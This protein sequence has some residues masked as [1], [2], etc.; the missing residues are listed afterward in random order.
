[1]LMAK[2]NYHLI[3]LKINI[4]SDAVVAHTNRLEKMHR[5]ALPVAI[6]GT[7]NDAAFDTKTRTMPKSANQFKKRSPNFFKANSKFEKAVGFDVNSMKSIVGFYENKLT[8]KSTNY[9]V[10]DLEQ[11]EHGGTI[12]KKSL[13]AMRPARSNNKLVRPAFRLNNL[14][15]L[16]LNLNLN[17]IISLKI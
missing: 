5:S 14:N 10:K 6:R 3:G 13:I 1:M 9:S 12:K 17:K 7:L 16:I 8:S 2:E 4:N 15:K 11:Q